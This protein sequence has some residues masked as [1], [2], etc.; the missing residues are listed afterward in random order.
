MKFLN[1]VGGP[2]QFPTFCPD[3]LCRVSFQR[4]NKS[5]SEDEIPERDV[6]CIIL[7][8]YLLTLIKTTEL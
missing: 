3:C 6:T 7:Y 2:S 8:V 1:D 4:Y 5:S